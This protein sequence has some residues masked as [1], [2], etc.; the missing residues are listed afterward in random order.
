MRNNITPTIRTGENT[1]YIS[2]QIQAQ[3]VKTEKL[4][5]YYIYQQ[6]KINSYHNLS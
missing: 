4:E 6:N 5:K 3:L 1:D 2:T